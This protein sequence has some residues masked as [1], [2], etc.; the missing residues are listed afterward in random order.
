LKKILF[1]APH[2]DDETLG[3]GGTIFKHL[4]NGDQVYWLIITNI[5]DENQRSSLRRGKRQDEIGT[6]AKMYKFVKTFMLDFP[7]TRLDEYPFSD[8]IEKVSSVINEVE[9]H[10][11]YVNNR[12]DVHTDHQIV[13]KTVLS[14]SKNF[15]YPFIKR[16]LMYETLSETE[17]APAISEYFFNPNV[18]T[19]ITN[20]F[21]MKIEVMKI[22][23]SELMMSPQPRSIDTIS[24]LASLRGSRIQAKYGEAFQLIFEHS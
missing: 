17:Y 6:V 10:T 24:A 23:K 7:T 2:P 14:C 3:C 11:I 18:Y 22:Y 1:V 20:Y 16:I 13:F 15:R 8:I 9:P 19:D 4:A 5:I 12:S 21:D